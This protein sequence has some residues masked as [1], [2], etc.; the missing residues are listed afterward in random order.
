LY[1]SQKEKN[2]FTAKEQKIMCC[3]RS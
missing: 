2:Y 1:F 3:W